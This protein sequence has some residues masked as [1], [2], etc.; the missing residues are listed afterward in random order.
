[1]CICFCLNSLTIFSIFKF[2]AL[3]SKKNGNKIKK[4]IMFCYKFKINKRLKGFSFI[5]SKNNTCFQC[6]YYY[7]FIQFF[8]SNHSSFYPSII[9]IFKIVLILLTKTHLNWIEWISFCIFPFHFNTVEVKSLTFWFWKDAK[10]RQLISFW[11]TEI[12]LWSTLI[13]VNFIDCFLEI[14]LDAKCFKIKILRI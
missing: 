8:F 9:F 3:Y 14:I 11:M 10:K 2:K 1:M 12:L 7:S 6:R 13:D 5:F 4:F